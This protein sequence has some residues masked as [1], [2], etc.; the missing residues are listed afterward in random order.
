MGVELEVKKKFSHKRRFPKGFIKNLIALHEQIRANSA[1]THALN[2][3]PSET[4]N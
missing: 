1:K 4:A 3:N 2:E